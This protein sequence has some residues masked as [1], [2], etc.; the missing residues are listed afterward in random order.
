MCCRL[1]PALLLLAMMHHGLEN[2]Q[3][4]DP[5][6]LA[7][8]HP[9]VR[10]IFFPQPLGVFLG[11]KVIPNPNPE[12]LPGQRFIRCPPAQVALQLQTAGGRGLLPAIQLKML[13]P[14]IHAGAPLPGLLQQPTQT[15]VA[16]GK[17]PFQK[18][19]PRIIAFQ[20]AVLAVEPFLD[21][22]H[23]RIAFFHGELRLPLKH[24]MG[25]GHKGGGADVHPAIA[26]F[27][28][29]QHLLGQ[30]RDRGHILLGFRG[31]AEHEVELDQF[32]AQAVGGIRRGQQVFL[33]DPLVDH[34]SQ[35]V[36]AGLR[37]QGKAGL[38]HPL[39]LLHD[40]RGEGADPQGR[41]GDGD[42]LLGKAVHQP[43]EQLA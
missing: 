40:R 29:L 4:A 18:A 32:P 14:G 22:I 43:D 28:G 17:N 20:G 19:H 39:D 30:G 37:G 10:S 25:L 35:P 31:Q 36:A 9:A 7:A 27:P 12:V 11:K 15:A 21:R 16:P 38:A 13:G 3:V 2:L 6:V 42:M 5:A 41:Q 34:P 33:G 24:G 1:G 8:M 26:A 23:P